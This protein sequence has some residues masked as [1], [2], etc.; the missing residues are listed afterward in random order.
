MLIIYACGLRGSDYQALPSDIPVVMSQTGQGM[1]STETQAQ[2]PKGDRHFCS[3][4]FHCLQWRQD[5][6]SWPNGLMLEA[7]LAFL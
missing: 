4:C 6:S 7:P 2:R 3:V 5:L 1:L